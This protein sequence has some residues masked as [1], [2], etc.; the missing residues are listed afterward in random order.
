LDEYYGYIA[1]STTCP[2]QRGT[3]LFSGKKSEAVVRS[4]A[5]FA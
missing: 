5:S 4:I 2:S 1:K 3:L